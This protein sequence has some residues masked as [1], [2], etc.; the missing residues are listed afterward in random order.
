MEEAT[1]HHHRTRN[2]STSILTSNRHTTCIN[3]H[4]SDRHQHTRT[5]G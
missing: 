3:T 2:T 5:R 1:H 4:R